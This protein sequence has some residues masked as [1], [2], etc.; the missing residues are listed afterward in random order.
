MKKVAQFSKKNSILSGLQS[1]CKE[2]SIKYN[3]LRRIIKKM[4]NTKFNALVDE[5]DLI[6]KKVLNSVPKLSDWDFNAIAKDVEK[7]NGSRMSTDKLKFCLNGLVNVGLVTLKNG[8]Y[9][10]TAIIEKP[11]ILRVDKAGITIENVQLDNNDLCINTINVI[12]LLSEL[13]VEKYNSDADFNKRQNR[14]MLQLKELNDNMRTYG[15]MVEEEGKELLSVK[16]ELEKANLKLKLVKD[17]H[18]LMNSL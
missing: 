12:A 7:N 14:L 5:L 10:Q 2:C 1:S 6:T 3:K 17:H 15:L 9:Q 8:R 4:N 16:V 13:H 11:K 18:E